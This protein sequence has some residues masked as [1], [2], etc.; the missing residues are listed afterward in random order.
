MPTPQVTNPA[1]LFTAAAPAGRKADAGNPAQSF[2][3]LLSREVAERQPSQPANAPARKE[4]SPAPDK[5]QQSA[6]TSAPSP[7]SAQQAAARGNA[8]D[9]RQAVKNKSSSEKT[10]ASDEASES[11]ETAAQSPEDLLAMVAGLVQMTMPAEAASDAA[12]AQAQDTQQAMVDPALLLA[13]AGMLRGDQAA[14]R[15]DKLE[16]ASD[17]QSAGKELGL[18]TD[19]RRTGAKDMLL[20]QSLAAK[21]DADAGAATDDLAALAAKGKELMLGADGESASSGFTAALQDT[22]TQGPAGAQAVP[23][24]MQ[25]QAAARTSETRAADRLTPAV[26]TPGWDQALG[27]K[28]VWMVAGEQQSASLTLN[29]PDL[30]PLQVVLNV[31]NSQATATFSA[32]QPEVRQA[33][34]AALPK[35]RDM[36]GEAGIQL[37]QATVNSGSPNQQSQQGQSFASRHGNRGNGGNDMNAEGNVAAVQPSRATA[38]SGGIGMVDTFV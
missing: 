3:Q 37:G 28:V 32:A 16:T 7:S 9:N 35:L 31:S 2:G 21:S 11:K 10:S 25:L 19:G 15:P 20:D 14:I 38:S 18:D 33:L 12:M 17:M 1:T 8:G 27:Q 5:A 26:G 30:G 6:S 36:L 23:Q 13:A 34:E 29:P 4:T 24:M 22:M